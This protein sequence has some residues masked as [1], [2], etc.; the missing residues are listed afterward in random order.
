[1]IGKLEPTLNFQKVL[2]LFYYFFKNMPLHFYA[3]K[4][5]QKPFSFPSKID[6]FN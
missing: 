5:G 2:A 1:M 6:S 4:I 3:I